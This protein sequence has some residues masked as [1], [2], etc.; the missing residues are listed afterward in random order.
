MH[1]DAA[2]RAAAYALLAARY[3]AKNAVVPMDAVAAAQGLLARMRPADRLLDA[4]CGAGR[5]VA[6]FGSP[7]ILVMGVD[8]SPAMLVHARTRVRGEL[9]ERR[10]LQIAFP[11]G[12]FNIV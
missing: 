5:D 3:A 1:H 6:W 10:L 4:G 7:C 12:T 2:R 8:Q 11:D 9:L